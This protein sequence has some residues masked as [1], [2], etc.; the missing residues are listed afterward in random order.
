MFWHV[1]YAAV[2]LIISLAALRLPRLGTIGCNPF[3][4]PVETDRA[5]Q[6]YLL[7]RAAMLLWYQLPNINLQHRSHSFPRKTMLKVTTQGQGRILP[8]SQTM[9]KLYV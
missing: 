6:G 9:N 8:L 2:V 5:I 3:Q 1:W 4:N 7:C